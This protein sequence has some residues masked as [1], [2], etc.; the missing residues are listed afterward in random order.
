MEE[1]KKVFIIDDDELLLDMYSLKFRESGFDVEIAMSGNQALDKIKSG[2]NPDVLLLDVVMP[3]MDGFEF[4]KKLRSEK[5][6]P[7]KTV[8]I[9]SNLGQREE[10]EKG[11]ALGIKN[12][13]IKAHHTPSEVVAK[14]KELLD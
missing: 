11:M 14:I 9:L 13:I 7:G 10:I 4:L 8:V 3:G 12:Y 6:I 1:K 2:F 5:L